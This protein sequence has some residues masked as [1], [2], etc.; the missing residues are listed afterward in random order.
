MN[1]S[2]HTLVLLV[3]MA[4]VGIA[5]LQALH[6]PPGRDQ[7][8]FATAGLMVNEGRVLYQEI[9]EVKQPFILLLYAL[10]LKIGGACA[11]TVNGVDQLF[12]LLVM[13]LF[14][15]LGTRLWGRRAGVT[16]AGVYGFMSL[17]L[18]GN[19]WNVSQAETFAGPLTAVA[20]LGLLIGR[21][22]VSYRPWC[23]AGAAGMGAV[24]FKATALVPASLVVLVPAVEAVTRKTLWRKAVKQVL[25]AVAGG[26]LVVAPVAGYFLYH[27]AVGAFLEVQVGFNRY[28]TWHYSLFDI[29]RIQAAVFFLPW[30]FNEGKPLVLMQITAVL[31]AVALAGKRSGSGRW[32][33]VWYVLAYLTV[34][35]QGKLWHYHHA[36]L[37]PPQVFLTV[38]CLLVLFRTPWRGWRIA[39][40]LV[41]AGLVGLQGYGLGHRTLRTL[42]D[43][44]ARFSGRMTHHEYVG[45]PRFQVQGLKPYSSRELHTVA[46]V[47]R[48]KGAPDDTLMVF[49]LDQTLNFLTGQLPPTRYMY[50]YPLL[51]DI[52]GYEAERERH[53]ALF[54]DAVVASPPRF[55]V[56]PE[57]PGHR[58]TTRQLEA[59]PAFRNWA[60][61][62]YESAGKIGGYLIFVRKRE[63]GK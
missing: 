7:G 28:H 9:F 3:L 16:A 4:V 17:A 22:G 29:A 23:L 34:P 46:A 53:R 13:P 40:L 5:G 8:I 31:G 41:L 20:F 2:K 11:E 43:D 60:I 15:L 19:F 42:G 26:L 56:I 47:L 61:S 1:M 25:A 27:G 50:S 58:P 24:L 21:D 45:L 63:E 12:R 48:E 32:L 39:G 59:F 36:L 10:A 18:Y 37:L 6:V 55:M 44:L 14:Y 57:G 52:E 54:L 33:V 38:W 51:A 49:G 30:D 62:M 35:L